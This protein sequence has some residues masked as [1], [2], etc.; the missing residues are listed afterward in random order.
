MG[1]IKKERLDKVLL[2]WYNLYVQTIKQKEG[3]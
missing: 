3:I 2:A 1:E